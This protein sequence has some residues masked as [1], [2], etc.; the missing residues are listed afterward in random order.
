MHSLIIKGY[1][2]P[3]VDDD[4][5]KL[6]DELTSEQVGTQFEDEWMQEF[7]NKNAMLVSVIYSRF[8]ND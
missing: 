4:A 8:M 5:W 2:R 7:R 3:I 1:K 6:Q